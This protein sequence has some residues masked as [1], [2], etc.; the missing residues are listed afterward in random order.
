MSKRAGRFVIGAIVILSAFCCWLSSQAQTFSFPDT[1]KGPRLCS[2]THD[3]P[4]GAPM[5][6]RVYLNGSAK[7]STANLFQ[8]MPMSDFGATNLVWVTATNEVGR[9]SDPSPVVTVNIFHV[10]TEEQPP[11]LTSGFPWH[12]T[13]GE[14]LGG[15]TV[16]GMVVVGGKYAAAVGGDSCVIHYNDPKPSTYRLTRASNKYETVHV[17]I[18]ARFPYFDNVPHEMKVQVNTVEKTVAVAGGPAWNQLT[19]YDAGDFPVGPGTNV[20]LLTGKDVSWGDIEFQSTAP[21]PAAPGGVL[22]E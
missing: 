16:S 6:F 8:S 12:P 11:V 17:R 18:K 2:W 20:I 3:N 13:K 7:Y 4:T 9:E 21:A 1:S 15:S 10:A 14:R 22:F 5:T 19:W